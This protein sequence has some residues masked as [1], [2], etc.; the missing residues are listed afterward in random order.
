MSIEFDK[1]S[2]ASSD[3]GI[4]SIDLGAFYPEEAPDGSVISSYL[5]DD[6]LEKH[7]ERESSGLVCVKHAKHQLRKVPMNMSSR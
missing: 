4:S 7:I 6:E 1:L 3:S 5:S 2:Q